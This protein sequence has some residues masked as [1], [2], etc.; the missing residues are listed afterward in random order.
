M[1]KI[2]ILKV[3]TLILLLCMFSTQCFAKTEELK[4]HEVSKTIQIENAEEYKNSI[5]KEIVVEEVNY[6]LK[7]IQETENK[8]TLT[9]DKEIQEQQIFKTN[10][11]YTA[12]NMFESEKQI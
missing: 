1:K 4:I 8:I 2:R 6:K 7:E 3:I 11:K 5:D 10:D 9:K 12:L